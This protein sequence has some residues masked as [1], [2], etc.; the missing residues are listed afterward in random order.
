MT[1]L[2]SQDYVFVNYVKISHL[3]LMP[4]VKLTDGELL[5]SHI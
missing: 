3:G 2:S 4:D 1:L 5:K